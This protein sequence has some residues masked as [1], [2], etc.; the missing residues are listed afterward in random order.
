[1]R[2]VSKNF[3]QKTKTHFLCSTMYFQNRAVYEI[4]WKNLVDPDRPQMTT[5]RMR[6]AFCIPTATNIF[7][8]YT[9]LIVYP[10][11]EWLSE[12]ASVLR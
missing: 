12:H 4:M 3:V 10:M 2:N 11:H 1:M 8:E 5:W 6:I 7:S 9:I